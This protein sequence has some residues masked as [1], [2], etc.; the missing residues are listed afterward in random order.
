MSD[1]SLRIKIQNGR[2]RKAMA[3][4]GIENAAQLARLAGINATQ[5]SELLNLK[6]A[7]RNRRGGWVLGARR[8]A[9]LLGILPEDLFTEQQ[10]VMVLKNN[11][12]ERFVS[13][14]HAMRLSHYGLKP[15]LQIGVD[16]TS[17]EMDFAKII[18]K[19]TAD[20]SMSDR[21]REMMR[22]RFAEDLP[23]LEVANRCGIG[24]ERVRQIEASFLRKCRAKAA[25]QKIDFDDVC[26]T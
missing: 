12:A 3:E 13:E 4:A 17:K 21:N 16:E 22:L 26:S 6:R 18:D 9:E 2:I 1:Y 20:I 10:Q 14:E 15:P 7:A 11:Q 8:L 19:I 23:L 24:A 5:L 25:A